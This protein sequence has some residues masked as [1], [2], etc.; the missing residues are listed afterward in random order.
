MPKN[1]ITMS[2]QPTE[3]LRQEPEKAVFQEAARLLLAVVGFM[4]EGAR[5]RAVVAGGGERLGLAVVSWCEK[6]T[7]FDIYIYLIWV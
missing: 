6:L 7:F 1:S 3:T 2:P 4:C 5:L